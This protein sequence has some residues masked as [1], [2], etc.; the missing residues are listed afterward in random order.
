MRKLLLLTAALCLISTSCTIRS[1]HW[2]NVDWFP[3]STK[4]K[5]KSTCWQRAIYSAL[6]MARAGYKVRIIR[7]VL[8]TQGKNTPHAHAKAEIKGEWYWLFVE[9]KEIR[10]VKKMKGTFLEYKTH[11]IDSYFEICKQWYTERR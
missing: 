10:P 8:I 5:V 7:G 2:D 9:G 4:A 6:V 3:Y 1:F 11:T